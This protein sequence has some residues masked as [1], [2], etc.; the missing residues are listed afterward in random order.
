M[1]DTRTDITR[2]EREQAQAGDLHVRLKRGE[3]HKFFAY[4]FEDTAQTIAMVPVDSSLYPSV[5]V[6]SPSNESL[7]TGIATLVSPG[8]YS[9]EWFV[10]LDADL[11]ADVRKYRVDWLII[12][13]G[14]RQTIYAET[15]EVFDTDIAKAEDREQVYLTL[16]GKDERLFLNLDMDPQEIELEVSRSTSPTQAI[17]T[18]KKANLTHVIDEDTHVFYVDFPKTLTNVGM[19]QAIWTVREKPTCPQNH[20]FQMIVVPNRCFLNFIPSMRMFIDKLQKRMGQ[21]QAY[22]DADLIEY[23]TQGLNIVNSWHP[24][25]IAFDVCALPPEL[26]PFLLIAAAL[27]GLNA[28]HIMETELQFS[29]GGQTVTLDYDHTG[30]YDSAIGRMQQYLESSPGLG[31]VKQGIMRRAT[32]TGIVA[33]RPTSYRGL[34]NFVYRVESIN[35]QNIPQ[36]LSLFGLL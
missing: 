17:F 31:N 36:L 13:A 11:S 20:F 9:F 14:G 27:W 2:E 12:T 24:N 16:Q 3:V 22:T 23:L 29:F 18:K 35:S 32:P 4:F 25:T 33:V 6:V 30:G 26:Q 19:Y 21:I 34:Y 1:S 7:Q 28:Q 8:L 5:E 15:F 10:P